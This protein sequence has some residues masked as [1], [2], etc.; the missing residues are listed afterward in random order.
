MKRSRFFT[1]LCVVLVFCVV[2]VICA[3]AQTFNSL[4]SFDEANGN[5]PRYGALVQGA[6]G[7]FYG[8]TEYGGANLNGEVFE[9]TASGMLTTLHSFCG[10]ANCAG[11]LQPYAAPVLATN[12]NFYGTT[13]NGGANAQGVVYEITPAGKYSVL[14]TF[15]SR[16]N[17]AD[18]GQPYAAP[19]QA[20]NGNLYGTASS[21]GANNQ[22]VV[23][24]ITSAGKY[25]PLYSF[26][27]LT[28]CADGAAPLAGLVQAANG[29]FYGTTWSDGAG[30]AGT[31]FEITSTGKLTTLHSFCDEGVPCTDGANPS[32]A[33]VQAANGNFYGTTQNGGDGEYGAGGTV[34]EITAAG[35]LTTL[36]TFCSLP[37]CADGYFPSG[38]LVQATSGDFYGTTGDGGAAGEGPNGTVFEITA[39]GKLTTLYNFCSQAG[40]TDGAV[41]LA[42]LLQATNGTFYGVTNQGGTYSNAEYCSNACGTV[43][44]LSAGLGPFVKTLPT[45]GKVGAT[46]IILGNDLTGASAVRFGGTAA[47][48]TVESSTEI[49]ATVPSGATTGTVDV[50]TSS[51][52]ALASNLSFR[53]MPQL[54]SFTPPGGPV[55]TVVTITGVSLTQTTEVAFGGVKATS[56]TVDSNTQVTATVPTGAKTGKITITTKGGTASS[57][58]S[59]TVSTS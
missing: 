45:S 31:V 20:S 42:G 48:F 13:W 59:F 8:T 54:T 22:G 58:T 5:G 30:A 19:I 43:F 37:D 57:A 2:G 34:F 14:Y 16:T 1:I 52:S 9:I 6:N 3:P 23:Y 17:C 51:G 29:D 46:V 38:A 33:L 40:C 15:C 11:G 41:P 55:G 21:G 32:A 50:T 10:E 47:T 27:S 44:S 7:N 26:C 53:V 56:L 28:N 24:E 39:K 36:Y 12:G 49:K 4:L 18:G 25:T 35:K